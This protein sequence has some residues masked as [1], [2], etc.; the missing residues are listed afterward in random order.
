MKIIVPK[1]ENQDRLAW[2]ALFWSARIGPA[3]FLRLLVRFGTARAIIAADRDALAAP[4]LKLSEEQIDS[5]V[6][7]AAAR[8]DTIEGEIASLEADG[9]RVICSFES[10]Y[11]AGFRDAANPPPVICVRGKLARADSP[12][13]AIVGTR[14]P[15]REGL[16]VAR[17]VAIACAQRA[18]TVVS[19][20]ARGIDGA[21]HRGA[22]AGGGRTVAI[23]GS[24]IRRVHPR[25]HIRLAGEIAHG[26]ALISALA[27]EAHPTGARLMARNRLISAL[28]DGVLAVESTDTGGTLQTVSDARKQKRLVFAC[29][30]QTPK[31]QAEGTR[32][33]IA[34]GAE[35]IL[36][37]DAIDVIEAMLRSHT[38]EPDQHSLI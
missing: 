38:S 32:G 24:G 28:A 12:A 20:L 19:G 7:D 8:L 37:A 10:E 17:E 35:P 2:S 31:P 34:E 6:T 5:I 1:A 21:A 11:P 33:L 22:L 29:D 14:E 13:L 23:L 9:V 15:T 25:R 36:G 18:I 16:R 26:G 30:W 3:G 27:P 4:S